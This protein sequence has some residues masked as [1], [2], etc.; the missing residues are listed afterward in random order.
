MT[1]HITVI[2]KMAERCNLD[3]T[4]CYMYHRGDQSWRFRPIFLSNDDMNSLIQRF[5]EHLQD[6]PGAAMLLEIHGGEPLLLGKEKMRRFLA[7]VRN[8][9]SPEQLTIGF[10]SNGIL[11][12]TDWLQIFD[13]FN[14]PIGISCD[15]PPEIHDR[16]RTFRHGGATGAIV[17]RAIRLC[18]DWPGRPVFAGVLAVAD[19]NVDGA[20]IVRYFHEL[21]VK[22]L[23]LLLPHAN[24]VLPPSH[25]QNYRHEGMLQYMTSAFDEWLR[26]G[27]TKIVLRQFQQMMLGMFGR[28][29]TAD[30][31]GSDLSSLLVVESDGTY[32]NVDVLRICGEEA[33]NTPF[34]VG[35]HSFHDF[36]SF[37]SISVPRPSATCL[38][39]TAFSSCGGGYLPHRFDGVGY[40][41]PSYY[42][43]VLLGLYRHIQSYIRVLPKVET[44][45]PTTIGAV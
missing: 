15:G 29:P 44:G 38:Q 37:A 39:C 33:V 9:L 13:E 16:Y 24:Y 25:L 28:S 26:I 42:C 11:L 1:E 6:Y 17:E 5:V 43:E 31:L 4:Y 35:V 34:H 2:A 30:A 36:T 40:D 20:S 3:C 23:D 18:V 27:T 10:Q 19:P 8:Q 12:D 32:Q 7:A 14:T 45:S 21:G 22:K 41:N